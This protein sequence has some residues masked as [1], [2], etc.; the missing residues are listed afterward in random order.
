MPFCGTHLLPC[1]SL[2]YLSKKRMP[3]THDH[4]IKVMHVE[5]KLMECESVVVEE[6]FRLLGINGTPIFNCSQ[7]CKPFLVIYQRV[8]V[9]KKSKPNIAIK[10]VE[11]INAGCST[12]VIIIL[13]AKWVK[14]DSIVFKESIPPTISVDQHSNQPIN[15]T[16]LNSRFLS[17]YG[18]RVLKFRDLFLM[19]HESKFIGDGV[20]AVQGISIIRQQWFNVGAT[21]TAKAL[22]LSVRFA[23]RMLSLLDRGSVFDYRQTG[24][25]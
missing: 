12:S 24:E 18:I 15:I 23:C 21:E 25:F 10:N 20:R 22:R 5:G 14:M 2:R 11:F 4:T 6:N 3:L 9:E 19:I 17:A 8:G 1:K 16:V 7:N 13:R